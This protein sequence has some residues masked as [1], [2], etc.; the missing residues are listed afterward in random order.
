VRWIEHLH[1]GHFDNRLDLLRLNAKINRYSYTRNQRRDEKPRPGS[2]R[3]QS[4]QYFHIGNV[5]ADLLM[6]FAKGSC[7]ERFVR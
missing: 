1:Q 6:K 5:N 3:R 7:F 2:V 4:T